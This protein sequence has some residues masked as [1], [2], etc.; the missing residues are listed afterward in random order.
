M[1][2]LRAKNTSLAPLVVFRII[3]GL[4]MLFSTLRFWIK[5]WIYSLYIAPEFHFKYYGFEWV[6]V[7]PGNW[8]YLVFIIMALSALGI[9]LGLFYRF[10]ATA[11]F[12]SFSYVE[13][14]DVATYLNHYYF[15][16]LVA[17][18]MIF[19]PAHRRSSL[20]VK[21][22]FAQYSEKTSWWAV[23]IIRVQL[24]LVYF[25]AGV[26][27]LN[28]DWLL[29]ALPLRIWLPANSDLPLIGF[30]LDYKWVAFAFSWFGALYDLSIPFFLWNKKTLPYAYITVIIF[31]VLTWI[32]FPIG[33]FPWVMIFSTL[34][35]FSDSYHEKILILLK[36]VFETP[37]QKKMAN[38]IA[39]TPKK[40]VTQLQA[41]GLA[42][43]LLWQIIWPWRFT[44][45]P[46]D[47][48]WTEQ[49]YRLSWRVMLMEKAGYI[50]YYISDPATG[51]KGEVHPGDYL[52]TNQEKQLATQP[53]LILQFAHYLE[54]IYHE[55]G[56]D[57][58]VIT[59]NAYVSLN[60]RGSRLF[61]DP[62]IDLTKEED[63]FSPKTWILP[64]EK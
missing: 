6:K 14:L 35:F 37:S 51:R 46:G 22:G 30:L 39:P 32:L 21:F 62:N 54:D 19:L 43:F 25:Y 61:I 20:D 40:W 11:F 52:T 29:E 10:S 24:A 16:S 8:L 64:N 28:P 44:A 15:V 36:S 41:A 48:F 56:I 26:A 13:L 18:L 57:H 5:G 60:G 42:L 55:K 23:N 3:F 12:L 31:H 34:I 53:D 17:F 47:L 63:S 4:L 7:I 50:T 1:R 59:A 38:M 9:A 27:K 58:P 49:G 45:Y 33:V 2:S